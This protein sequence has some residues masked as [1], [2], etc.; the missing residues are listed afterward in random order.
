MVGVKL[1]DTRTLDTTTIM[2]ALK[3]W[4]FQ[5]QLVKPKAFILYRERADGGLGL[6]RPKVKAQ[7]LFIKCYLKTAL[8]DNQRKP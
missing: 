7:A 5:D 4:L 3:S 6:I 1:C 2:A 8:G